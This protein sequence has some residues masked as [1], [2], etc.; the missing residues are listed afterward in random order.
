[1]APHIKRA[2]ACSAAVLLSTACG[3]GNGQSNNGIQSPPVLPPAS[4]G[5]TVNAAAAWLQYLST[6]RRWDIAGQQNGN[7]YN[8]ALVLTP[9]PVSTFPYSG[10]LASTTT[11]SLRLTFGGIATADTDGILYYT[12]DGLIGIVGGGATPRCAV[13]R[14]PFTPLP[15]NSRVGDGGTIVSLDSLAGCAPNADRVGTVTLTWSI[16]Q[17]LAV[18]LFCL[19]TVRQDPA[20]VPTGS[21]TACV[22]SDA[23]GE[24]AGGARLSLRRPDGTAISGKNY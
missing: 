21:E 18:T 22:Q 12:G 19:T 15:N 24:L 1:M 2:L 17:D 9:G 13:I 11:Q 20:G 10:Q 23:A 16:E 6:P 14:T 4:T 5:V 7:A 3:G 8:L